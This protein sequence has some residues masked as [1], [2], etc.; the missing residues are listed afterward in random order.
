[1]SAVSQDPD[2]K[3]ARTLLGHSIMLMQRE[4]DPQ[5]MGEDKKQQHPSPK[6]KQRTCSRL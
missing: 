5:V 4:L 2:K 3:V 6:K 1:M